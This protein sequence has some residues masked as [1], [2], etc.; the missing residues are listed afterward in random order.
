M[1]PMPSH[2]CAESKLLR[3][4]T[5]KQ[6]SFMHKTTSLM[7]VLALLLLIL[8]HHSTTAGGVCNTGIDSTRAPFNAL[9]TTNACGIRGAENVCID[10]SVDGGVP[11]AA[12]TTT[13]ACS[14]VYPYTGI[15]CQDTVV[16]FSNSLPAL[17]PIDGA[18]LPDVGTI[19]RIT[20]AIN[21]AAAFVD[22]QLPAQNPRQAC[23]VFLRRRAEVT[24]ALSL[25]EDRKEYLVSAQT[26]KTCLTEYVLPSL[27]RVAMQNRISTFLPGAYDV[28]LKTTLLITRFNYPLD[29]RGAEENIQELVAEDILNPPDRPLPFAIRLHPILA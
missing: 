22:N 15:F 5:S 14:C 11:L 4:N 2:Q 16:M 17:I 25:D 27:T 23:Q 9:P 29:T 8:G 6:N 28:V 24:N 21:R 10:P 7:F 1:V 12:R 3:P 26:S 13:S 20:I 18:N 19:S